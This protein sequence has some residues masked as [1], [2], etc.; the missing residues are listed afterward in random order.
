MVIKMMILFVKV[1]FG[2]ELHPTANYRAWRI[3]RTSAKWWMLLVW[4]VFNGIR[5]S[6]NR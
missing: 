6:I 5:S 4:P 2:I 3:R 1:M